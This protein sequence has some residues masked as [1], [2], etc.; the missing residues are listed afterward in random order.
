VN[1]QSAKLTRWLLSG[2]GA[3]K[4]F[5]QLLIDSF[6]PTA[7]AAATLDAAT[8]TAYPVNPDDR[9]SGDAWSPGAGGWT[10]PLHSS[11]LP[12]STS[13]EHH[14]LA[15]ITS[16]NELLIVNLA[17]VGY[18]GIEGGDAVP[19]MRSWLMQVLSKTP[20]AQV[21]VTDPTLTIPNAPRL[22]LIQTVDD[23]A[24]S[25]SIVFTTQHTSSPSGAAPTVVS[26][27]AAS[28]ANVV[29]INDAAAGIYLA[30]RY[31]PVW[32]RMELQEAQ[33]VS[34]T[35]ALGAPAQPTAAP[36]P[37]PSPTSTQTAPTAVSAGAAEPA[38]ITAPNGSAALSSL[39]PPADPDSAPT[40]GDL[41]SPQ[42]QAPI[43]P[44][45]GELELDEPSAVQ[46]PFRQPAPFAEDDPPAAHPAPASPIPPLLTAAVPAPFATADNLDGDG[47]AADEQP[48]ILP[49]RPP[50]KPIRQG[51]YALGETYALGTD[52]DTGVAV[53][54]SAVTRQGV[55][56]PVKALMALATSSGIT[57]V[58]W[59][60]KILQVTAQ[61]RRQM[62]TQIRK[63]MGGTDPIHT[64]ARGLLVVDLF[65]DWKEFIR[66]T[67][68]N[69]EAASTEDL[70]A[71][72]Q[73][74]R[75]TPFEDV[76][77]DEYD[78]RAV[79]LLK[80]EL[81]S[82]CSS[83]ALEL[84]QRHHSAGAAA[85]A[86]QAARIGTRVYAQREDLWV[87]AATTVS[88][89][90]RPGLIW[91]LKQAIPVPTRPELKQLLTASRVHT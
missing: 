9:P 38:S 91:D 60:D 24:A 28:A 84:A 51:L 65:C 43:A 90:D 72:V 66:L 29:L 10:H 18:L 12:R 44:A 47:D 20:A 57:E 39:T 33:W 58:E 32:R 35:N 23:T 19:M 16:R 68:H 79:Q 71:A 6:G 78:W 73:L 1:E 17:A 56:K 85:A 83:A 45:A 59:Q 46:T 62:K 61:N 80:D 22:A 2:N 88:D 50:D 42:V 13:A 26:S 3:L 75:G 49:G 54:H 74:I 11:L 86:Y 52:P 81:L 5:A 37:N 53:K 41:P 14:V 89:A 40:T 27:Q 7:V 82:V 63:M 67:G 8:I 55:R 15:G 64:D 76:P 30:N 31:W 77:D 36:L 48:P 87:I 34:L 4:N 25:T 70:T 69:P 21:A